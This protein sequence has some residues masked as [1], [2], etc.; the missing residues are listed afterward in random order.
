LA[1]AGLRQFWRE[2]VRRP[3]L[4]EENPARAIRELPALRS[5]ME[6]SL[7]AYD[8][9]LG[10]LGVANGRASVTERGEDHGRA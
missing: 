7:E 1:R 10:M 4:V 3:A 9:V 5:V 8:E 6:E 2:F